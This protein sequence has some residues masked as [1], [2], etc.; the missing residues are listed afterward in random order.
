MLQIGSNPSQIREGEQRPSEMVLI[1]SGAFIYRVSEACGSY[2]YGLAAQ[3][4]SRPRSDTGEL[5]P[6]RRDEWG[7]AVAPGVW[8]QGALCDLCTDFS[9][10]STH[11]SP[12]AVIFQHQ[13]FIGP[14]GHFGRI[15][16]ST[17]FDPLT[18]D[19]QVQRSVRPIDF[20]NRV[21]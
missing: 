14:I 2:V 13:I 10:D 6:A 3:Q 11:S 21:G 1:V 17:V 20:S 12:S 19:V 8:S 9:I 5:A 18:A 16:R 7:S 4:A 15:V